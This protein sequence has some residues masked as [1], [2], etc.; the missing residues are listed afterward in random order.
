M[1]RADY[2]HWNEEQDL[3][4]WQEE[5]RHGSEEPSWE[6]DEYSSH[7]D[8]DACV[9]CDGGGKVEDLVCEHCGGDGLEP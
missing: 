2:A 3:V 1:S 7:I 5:G 4:W 6:P 8:Y 9:E